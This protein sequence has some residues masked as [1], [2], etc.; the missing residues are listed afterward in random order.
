ME[1]VVINHHKHD[2]Y[3]MIRNNVFVQNYF[4]QGIKLLFRCGRNV[5][6][7]SGLTTYSKALTF[8]RLARA[9]LHKSCIQFSNPV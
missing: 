9:Y 6:W 7:I 1:H 5:K 2:M 3:N 8:Y 4:I